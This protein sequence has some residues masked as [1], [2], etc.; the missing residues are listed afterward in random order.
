LFQRF[1][2]KS[3]DGLGWTDLDGNLQYANKTLA[4]LIGA[5]RPEDILACPIRRFY[6]EPARKRFAEEIFPTLRRDGFWSGELT[7]QNAK[8]GPI[9]VRNSFFGIRDEQGNLLGFA[10]GVTDLSSCRNIQEDVHKQRMFLEEGVAERLSDLQALNDELNREIQERARAEKEIE[11]HK[12]LLES[13]MLQSPVPMVLVS[14]PDM[15]IRIYNHACRE[16]LGVTDEP[17]ATGHSLLE[18]DPTWQDFTLEGVPVDLQEM[19]LGLALRGIRTEKAEFTIRRKDGSVRYEVVDGVPIHDRD[20]HLIAGFIIFPD[21]TDR[22]LA[23]KALREEKLF[24]DAAVNSLP[25]LFYV[26]D[27]AGNLQR[28]NRNFEEIG[29]YRDEEVGRMNALD[30]FAPEDRATVGRAIAEVFEQ[31]SA[32]VES[33]FL[34]KGHQR[35]PYLFTGMKT[36]IQGEPFLVGMG[37]DITERKRAEDDLVRKTEELDRFFT[38]SLDLLCIADTDGHFRRL[39]PEWV[40]VL[41]YDLADLVGMRFMD[42]VHPDD[43]A[44]TLEAVSQL[45]AQKVVLNF[46][47]RYRCRDGSYRWIEWRSYPSGNLIYAAARDITDSKRAEEA[48]RINNLRRDAMLGLNERS[49]GSWTEITD[50]A[51]EEIVRITGSQIG[52]VAFLNDS[53]DVLTMYSWSRSA[54]QECRI[55]EKPIVYPLE[56]T[57]LWGEAVRQRRPIIT[58]DY[59]EDNPWKRGV[60]PGH[61]HL[62]RHLNLPLFDQDRIVALVGVGNKGEPY[63]Q[64]DIHQITLLSNY[65][66]SVIKNRRAEEALRKSEEQYRLLA[67][68][69]SDV[70]WT[71]DM[72]MKATYI[73]PSVFRQRGYTVAEAMAQPLAESMTEDSYRLVRET[74]ATVMAQERELHPDRPPT[75]TLELEMHH[76]NGSTVWAEATAGFVRDETGRA[77]G[78]LGI[79]R[80]ITERKRAQ[81]EKEILEEQ[82]RQSQ[83]M[84]AIGR[85]AGGVAHDFNNIMT[86]ITGYAEMI[87]QTV[88]LD[89]A[90]R[91]DIEEI[92]RAGE[93]AAGLTNQLLAFSRKQVIAPKVILPNAVIER[94]EKMLRRIIGEDI[95]LLFRPGEALGRI[96][97]DPAQIDQILVNLAVNARDA[98]PG[99]GRLTLETQNV[100]IDEAYCRIHGDAQPGEFVMMAVSDDGQGMDEQTLKQI[101]EPFF[102]T[103]PKDR[104]TGLGLATVYGIVRQ[105]NGFINVYSEPNVGSSFKIFFPRVFEEPQPLGVTAKDPQHRGSETVL[106]VE[107]ED[108]VRGLAKRVLELQGYTVLEAVDGGRACLECSRHEGTIHLLLTDVIMP[109]MNGRE[110]YETLRGMKPELKVLFMSGY[111]E[112]VIAQHG[113]LDPGTPFIQ[114]PFTI[115][116]LACKVREVLDE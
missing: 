35:I 108:M 98:M 41:G 110:L 88:E 93:R 39:N 29:G 17:D 19:P 16:I 70:I 2:E 22:K 112:N 58:N 77:V 51:L 75:W 63:D 109:A 53:E 66:W 103:K 50:Y 95:D 61:V 72:A 102:T 79:S 89:D 96:K 5:D 113:V 14:Y 4:R 28:W 111:T 1:L 57:G 116:S 91:A 52:Y 15:K 45:A 31:G 71:R 92:R 38:A 67:E 3:G 68:N 9:P 32:T 115:E 25:G 87:L 54:M 82:L 60:P 30:F 81:A 20:G 23:E 86:G 114:K 42:L 55:Q 94:S 6:D 37:I 13:V 78:I 80:D 48:Q 47:N 18:F 46:V 101:F 10:S 83:K 43:R 49:A 27:G 62:R 85:L 99:G 26:L 24:T 40:K 56:T 34:T 64:E 90:L 65:M 100:S 74:L 11:R 69:A 44:D 104:G 59:G 21:I 12:S 73:S 8:T 33:F 97:A 107:D 36:L 7:L 84:E 76:K 106:L 105:N